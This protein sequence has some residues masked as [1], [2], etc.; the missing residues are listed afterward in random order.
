VSSLPLAQIYNHCAV[1]GSLKTSGQPTVVQ[2]GAN[3]VGS[4]V[5]ADVL[6]DRP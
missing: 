6:G 3:A 1:D 5:I 4:A 2:S